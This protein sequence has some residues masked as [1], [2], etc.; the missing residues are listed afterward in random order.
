MD[1]LMN[2]CKILSHVRKRNGIE[3]K[4][5]DVSIDKIHYSVQR[6]KTLTDIN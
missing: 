3:L 1:I 2:D 5:G 6:C 4:K